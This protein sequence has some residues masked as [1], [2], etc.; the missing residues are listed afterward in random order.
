[1]PE[2]SYGYVTERLMYHIESSSDQN[3]ALFGMFPRLLD[4]VSKLTKLVGGE[5]HKLKDGIA[6]KM[7][8]ISRVCGLD[9][10]TPIALNVLKNFKDI[11]M[12]P[13][14]LK[15]LVKKSS[16]Y[17]VPLTAAQGVFAFC[18]LTY[19]LL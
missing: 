14:E 11:P 17:D 1:M 19:A 8:I 10:T 15:S 9:W 2:I 4:L 7:E 6:Y 16:K 18:W 13:V 12:A 3:A 5:D